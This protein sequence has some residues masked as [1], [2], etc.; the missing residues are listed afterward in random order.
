MA[1][2]IGDGNSAVQS[3]L[4]QAAGQVE[5][6]ALDAEAQFRD[7]VAEMLSDPEVAKA[8]TYHHVFLA[9]GA[10]V[11]AA[12]GR[13]ERVATA[14]GIS[15]TLTGRGLTLRW[16]LVDYFNRKIEGARRRLGRTPSRRPGPGVPTSPTRTSPPS[17][18]MRQR[19][20]PSSLRQNRPI[21]R[22][23]HQRRI[24]RAS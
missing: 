3:R 13:W 2:E 1:D 12:A 22:S 10:G 20:R 18:C 4:A 23:A 6:G 19:D 16:D 24:P 21:A 11:D 9:F 7:A 14:D 8:M 15:E 17:S 5:Q